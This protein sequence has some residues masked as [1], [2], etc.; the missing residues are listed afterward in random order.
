[1]TSPMTDTEPRG[2]FITPLPGVVAFLLCVGVL[3][4]GLKYTFTPPEEP[5]LL[6]LLTTDAEP[7]R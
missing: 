6:E 1:M 2:R 5:T 3:T 7:S 4:V